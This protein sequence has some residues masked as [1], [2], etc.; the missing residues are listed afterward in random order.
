ML[1]DVRSF[2]RVSMTS[3]VF[4]NSHNPSSRNLD[5]VFAQPL[6]EISIRCGKTMFLGNKEAAGA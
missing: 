3:L 6:T 1:Q 4:F 5:L 2:A